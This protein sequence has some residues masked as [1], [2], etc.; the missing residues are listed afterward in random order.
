MAAPPSCLRGNFHSFFMTIFTGRGRHHSSSHGGGAW[1]QCCHVE[2]LWLQPSWDISLWALTRS[3]G[4]LCA[5]SLHFI[6]QRW[7]LPSCFRLLPQLSPSTANPKMFLSV[8]QDVYGRMSAC[9]LRQDRVPPSVLD[10]VFSTIEV[11]R[12]FGSSLVS[13]GVGD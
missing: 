5:S 12:V 1:G 11:S 8:C 10:R 4:L 3:S 2:Q 6:L 9:H 13:L 7:H